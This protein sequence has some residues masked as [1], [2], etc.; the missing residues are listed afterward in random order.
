MMQLQ[1]LAGECTE[2]LA[3]SQ[4]HAQTVTV[5]LLAN[6]QLQQDL[7]AAQELNAGLH[8]TASELRHI[9]GKLEIDLAASQE[10]E[11]KLREVLVAMLPIGRSE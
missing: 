5:A 3:A 1:V 8:E 6:Q 9:R 10:Q 4:E 11:R 2:A 7:A